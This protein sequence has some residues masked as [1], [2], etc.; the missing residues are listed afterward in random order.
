M[1]FGLAHAQFETI[2]P[3]LDGN[4]RVGRLLIALLLCERS[5]LLKPVLYL[6]HYL[7]RHR[8]QY[9]EQLQAIRDRGE[10]EPWIE[11][12][13]QGVTQVSREA[14][15]TARRI[16]ALREKHRDII[17]EHFGR[18]ANKG[19][20]ILEALFEQPII[21]V[22]SVAERLGVSNQAAGDLVGRFIEHGILEE[23]TGF[24]RNRRYRY[25]GY[26]SL[27]DEGRGASA[28]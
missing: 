7:K 12:F 15:E 11:F 28:G 9:Y 13:L 8:N 4:G 25:A 23:I 16:L 27:F 17:T 20:R 5:V 2:H 24:Q 1:K 18:V 6:S 26:I 22:K 21:N 14:T 3:F 10:W 19:Y